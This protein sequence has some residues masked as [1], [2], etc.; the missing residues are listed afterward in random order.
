M[1]TRR[2]R[3][4]FLHFF[5]LKSSSL[6]GGADWNG[7]AGRHRFSERITRRH[8]KIDG[9]LINNFCFSFFFFFCSQSIGYWRRWFDGFPEQKRKKKSPSL[10]DGAHT[11]QVGRLIPLARFDPLHTHTKKR[12][13]IY[14][15]GLYTT[16]VTQ[17]HIY[18]YIWKYFIHQIH[19]SCS[20][21]IRRARYPAAAAAEAFLLFFSG[22]WFD[23]S[24]DFRSSPDMMGRMRTD[25]TEITHRRVDRTRTKL[26]ETGRSTGFK[27]DATAAADKEKEK[28]KE[29]QSLK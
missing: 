23:W 5:S 20:N 11:T 18:I 25:Y 2:R 3:R 7:W 17:S 1:T 28:K 22:F 14:I 10:F 13:G 29:R 21:R 26:K 16:A 24:I 27:K 4:V 19:V 12:G 8:I 15:I 9:F 6:R